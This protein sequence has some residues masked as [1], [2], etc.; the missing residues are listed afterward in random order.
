MEDH[1]VGEEGRALTSASYPKQSSW[2]AA[3]EVAFVAS[4]FCVTFVVAGWM[5][6]QVSAHSVPTTVMVFIGWL[7]AEGIWSWAIGRAEIQWGNGPMPLALGWVVILF[8]PVFLSRYMT[9]G[10]W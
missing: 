8:A 6:Y 2:S 10:H 9:A 3:K 1:Y 4:P 5:F 7:I